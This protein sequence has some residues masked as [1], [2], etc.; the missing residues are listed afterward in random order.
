MAARRRP[1]LSKYP[2]CDT[3]CMYSFY[4]Y[5]YLGRFVL[6]A[7]NRLTPYDSV[8][9]FAGQCQSHESCKSWH[10]FAFEFIIFIFTLV[11][12]ARQFMKFPGSGHGNDTYIIHTSS[13]SSSLVFCN[14]TSMAFIVVISLKA[15]MGRGACWRNG[16]LERKHYVSVPSSA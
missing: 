16:W 6:N 9:L 15:A 7:A 4:L 10:I 5:E 13:S 2:L 12:N 8:E 14:A 1:A 11:A 3:G